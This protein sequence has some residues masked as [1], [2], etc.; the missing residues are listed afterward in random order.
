[1]FHS[2]NL[3]IYLF[4]YLHLQRVMDIYF[5][6]WLYNSTLSFFSLKLCQLWP[7]KVPSSWHLYPLDMPHP[8]LCTF[9]FSSITRCSRLILSFLCTSPCIGHFSKENGV[10]ITDIWVFRWQTS[11]CLDDISG[12]LD[13]RYLG[14][15]LLPQCHCSLAVGRT[16]TNPHT[17]AMIYFC[18]HLSVYIAFMSSS[19]SLQCICS[20][21]FF[22]VSNWFVGVIDFSR[23]HCKGNHPFAYDTSFKYVLP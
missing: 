3:F 21:S 14:V 23:G 22:L 11:G 2:P 10:Q 9:L 19:W 15:A 12:C 16:P 6:L 4:R 7:P 17:R 8:F 18:N 1:M 20:C 13:D 5:I